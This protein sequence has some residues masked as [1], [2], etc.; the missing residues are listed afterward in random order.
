MTPNCSDRAI[1]YSAQIICKQKLL[2]ALSGFTDTLKEM[3]RGLQ[4]L[5][6]DCGHKCR[7]RLVYHSL[8][9]IQILR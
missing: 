1:V 3:E 7:A 8:R 5:Q 2:Q 9:L 6:N 4:L